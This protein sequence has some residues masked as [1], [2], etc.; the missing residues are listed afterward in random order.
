MRT[1]ITSFTMVGLGY[2]WKERL[3][4]A[5]AWTPKATVQASLSAYPLYLIQLLIPPSDPQYAEWVKWGNEILT[6]G[7]FAIIICGTVGTLLV[8]WTAP[9]LLEQGV[10]W[11]VDCS[12]GI[13]VC[14]YCLW[15]MPASCWRT[16]MAASCVKF[17]HG[18]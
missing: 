3:F 18:L 13:C 9:L 7:I 11:D 10:G 8:F 6:T 16:C 15:A 2:N 1:I 5:V 4:Y 14:M 12:R 17:K